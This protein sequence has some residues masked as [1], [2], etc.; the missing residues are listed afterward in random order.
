MAVEE[1]MIEI[2]S[3]LFSYA[4]FH[5]SFLISLY[6]CCDLYF[7]YLVFAANCVS[8]TLDHKSKNDTHAIG[9]QI[10]HQM[11]GMDYTYGLAVKKKVA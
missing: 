8:T 1:K 3:L 6:M 10:A 4:S 9:V 5:F 7:L 11:D 2:V